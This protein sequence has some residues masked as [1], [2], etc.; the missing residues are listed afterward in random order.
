MSSSE[1]FNSQTYFPPL[2]TSTLKSPITRLDRSSLCGLR[3]EIVQQWHQER[4]LPG[5]DGPE[6]STL[7]NAPV[8]EKPDT[9]KGSP[10]PYSLRALNWDF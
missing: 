9:R 3:A 2:G 7:W 1:A 10:G 4:L 8:T 5:L 6:T